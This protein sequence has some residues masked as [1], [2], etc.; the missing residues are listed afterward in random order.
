MNIAARSFVC[1]TIAGLTLVCSAQQPTQP[2]WEA[3]LDDYEPQLKSAFPTDERYRRG[4]RVYCTA[5]VTGDDLDEAL[6]TLGY[7]GAYTG[8]QALL[9]L[10]N[11]VPAPTRYRLRD[12]REFPVTLLHGSSAMNYVA[13]ALSPEERAISQIHCTA[14]L[15]ADPN[16]PETAACTADSYVWNDQTESFEYDGPLSER[17]AGEYFRRLR[18]RETSKD[19]RPPSQPRILTECGQRAADG[20]P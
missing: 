5:D 15:N 11:G 3:L 2:P 7:G 9:R 1:A 18:E 16:V 6:V 4:I 12:G 10:E 19:F 8:V 17:V 14:A 13:F 20:A